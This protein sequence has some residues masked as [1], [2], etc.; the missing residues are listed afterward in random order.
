MSAS[1]KSAAALAS[2]VSIPPLRKLKA[3][4]YA[5]KIKAYAALCNE[6]RS[7]A[8]AAKAAD[9]AHKAARSELLRAMDGSPA[10]SCNGLVLTYKE[11]A[12]ADASITTI[13]G[14]RV[15]WSQVTSVLIGN[16]TVPAKDVKSLFGGRAGS[17]TLDVTGG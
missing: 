9:D 6:K 15:M 14:R 3:A 10:A 16:E 2:A 1:L 11:G 13:D 5:F 12:A 4:D 8:A 17:I 7:T